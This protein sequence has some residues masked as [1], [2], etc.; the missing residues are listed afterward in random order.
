MAIRRRKPTSPGRGSK[1]SR[2]SRRSPDPRPRSRS[3]AARARPAAATTTA[4][5]PPSP[6]W[7]PQAAVPPDR[8]PSQQGRRAR[9]GGLDRVRPQSHLSHRAAALPR[10]REALHPRPDGVQVGD[11][12]QYGQGAEIRPGNALPLRYIPV[13]T[14]VH[15]IEMRP[16]GGGK[17]AR[18]A[19]ASV[20][21]V[22]KEG[23]YAT[24]ACPAP[25]CVA[26]DRL[27]S[28]RRHHRQRRPRA[29]SR[30]ARPAATAGRASAPRPVA[31]P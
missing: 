31:S 22:A 13:G 10:R 3:S 15:N 25:R 9:L 16:G 27:S 14:V 30:S 8:L 17:M 11:I 20:Q 28:H 23:D 29:R 5:R 4:A 12:L 24:C 19:G 6:R 1:P 18:S 21:L 7:R 26:S 2:T